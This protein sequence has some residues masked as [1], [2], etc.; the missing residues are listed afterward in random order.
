MKL[1][2]WTQYFWPE[3]F[4]INKLVTELNEQGVEVTVITG[5]PNYPDGDIFSGYKASGV[6]YERYCGVDVV[7]LPLVPRGKNSARKLLLNYLSFI[8]SG[9]FF[10][11]W[12]LRGEKF[13]A[14][15]VYAPS[16]LLQ[17]LPAIFVS[18]LKHAPLIVWVQDTWPEALQAT[19]FIKNSWLL[20][21][22]ELLVR[23]IYRF[24]DSILIQSKAFQ[25]SV[26]A[27]V[28]DKKKVRFFPNFSE[29]LIE[30][31]SL[32]KQGP[33]N[34][35]PAIVKAI[36]SCFSIV[37]AGN[38]GSAQSCETI[39]QA[40]ELLSDYPDIVFYL[41]GSGS[42]SDSIRQDI[43]ARGLSNVV[44]TGR[45]PPEDIP[46]IYSAAEILL[47]TLK[48]NP[49][50]YATIPSKM[51]SYMSAAK[52]ILAS[53]NGEAARLVVAADA[54]FSCPAEAYEDLAA[55][56][57]QLYE[58]SSDERAQLGKNARH[59]YEQHFHL[60]EKLDELIEHI[61]ELRGNLKTNDFIDRK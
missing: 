32:G 12:A 42:R 61:K 48:D 39:V 58:L 37:F 27:L 41:V 3:N 53:L 18:W 15:F 34:S 36:Q 59:Y 25:N 13:D 20:K 14:V 19:G 40:A 21:F 29:D 26:Q 50:L 45:L 54:G 47:V 16:P 30:K 57:L 4:L 49:A 22:V 24:S 11:P 56:V 10:A 23:Y 7:R 51:Q 43:Q 33:E 6:Q 2:V 44:M 17:A 38:I 60:T 5:K 28:K 52:P 8:F 55:T 35:E 9:Y 1:L 46:A 31:L